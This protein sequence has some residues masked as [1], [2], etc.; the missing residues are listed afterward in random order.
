MME[1]KVRLNKRV[2][3]GDTVVVTAGNDRGKSGKV[4]SRTTDR[5]LIEGVN[6]RKKTVR[7]SEA[8]QKGGF[9]EIERAIHA[10]NVQ[11]ATDAGKAVRLKS[12]IS[13]KGDKELVFTEGGKETVYR[14][15]RKAKA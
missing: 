2:R 8:N 10:S 4:L 9:I 5:I 6:I 1:K 12:R 7:P 3:V 13:K 14:T 11:A 15:V